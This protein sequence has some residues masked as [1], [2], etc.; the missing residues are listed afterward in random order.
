MT[1]H[2]VLAPGRA[3]RVL[4][5]L[6]TALC[7]VALAAASV[8]AADSPPI[9]LAYLQNDLHHLALSVASSGPVPNS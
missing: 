9:R 5:R 3:V 6:L 1:L 8:G 2:T 4:G 7:A